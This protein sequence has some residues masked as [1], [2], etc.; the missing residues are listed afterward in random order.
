LN[1]S[2]FIKI[3][4][5]KNGPY[6]IVVS[7][8]DDCDEQF[9]SLQVVEMPDIGSVPYVNA[10][11]VVLSKSKKLGFMFDVSESIEIMI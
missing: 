1:D 11:G 9:Y 10:P 3:S 8:P 5:P 6:K 4:N 7:L 2:D